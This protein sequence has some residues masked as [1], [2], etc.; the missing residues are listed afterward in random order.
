MDPFPQKW[1]YRIQGLGAWDYPLSEEAFPLSLDWKTKWKQLH[2]SFQVSKY[3]HPIKLL[4]SC[5]NFLNCSLLTDLSPCR[6]VE[7]WNSWC[8]TKEIGNS[9]TAFYR[10]EFYISQRIRCISTANRPTRICWWIA[11]SMDRHKTTWVISNGGQMGG[12]S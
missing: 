1:A 10:L 7:R 9:K 2:K 8:G 5:F 3:F 6:Y 12:Q 11:K 4:S